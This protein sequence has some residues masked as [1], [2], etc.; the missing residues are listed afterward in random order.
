MYHTAQLKTTW[1]KLND[2]GSKLL[3]VSEN[4]I[5]IIILDTSFPLY[6]LKV[7]IGYTEHCKLKTIGKF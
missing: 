7:S 3:H 2:Q 6:T 5:N 4:S 1:N